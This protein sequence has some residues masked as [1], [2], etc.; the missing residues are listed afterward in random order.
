MTTAGPAGHNWAGNHTYRANALHTPATIDELRRIVAGAVRVRALGSRHSFNDL[1][2]SAELVS[3]AALPLD[4]EIDAPA[5]TVTCSG[6]TTYGALADAL[7][8]AG[9]AL[10]NLASLPHISVAGA[11]ATATHGSGDANG[12]LA[13]AV[14]GLELVTSSGDIVQVRRDHAD[15]D[16]MVVGLGALGVVTRVTLDLEPAYD[17]RQT[18]YEGLSWELLA[19]HFDAVTSAGYSVSLFTR[20]Q[21]AVDQVWVKTRLDG[22]PRNPDP[23]TFLGAPAAVRDRHPV[24][25]ASPE[26]CTPQGGVAG[27]WSDRLPHFRMGFTPSSGDEIQSEFHVP[28]RNALAAIDVMRG[29][30]GE[31]EPHLFIS[32]IRTVASDSLWMSAQHESDTVALHVTWRPH[33]AEVI[34]LLQRFEPRLMELGAVP[35]WGKVFVSD[36]SVLTSAVP[37]LGDFL[38]LVDRLDPRGAFRN[39][40]FIRCFG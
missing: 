25:G 24:P 20:W 38:R 34:E 26:H 13:T 12:N 19:D 1:A 40:W 21:D 23:P 16:G 8:P 14:R 37:R 29:L 31:I 30:A 36:A 39:E 17:V 11:I 35:H 15:F 18:V 28:R 7:R 32:E 3:L 10:H 22:E 6:A 33:P 5:R 9:L 4:I 27:P 2:D